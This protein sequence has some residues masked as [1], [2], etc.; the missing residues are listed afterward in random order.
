MDNLSLGRCL[1]SFCVSQL[2]T[3]AY[4]NNEHIQQ[5]LLEDAQ[6]N[7]KGHSLA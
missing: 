6:V 5:W 4:L 3:Q 2:F 1:L 7:I